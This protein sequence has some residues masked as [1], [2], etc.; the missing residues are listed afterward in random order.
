MTIKES[1]TIQIGDLVRVIDDIDIF[2]TPSFKLGQIL[3]VEGLSEAK[4][5]LTFSPPYDAG[6]WSPWRFKLYKPILCPEYL[7]QSNNNK[8][9]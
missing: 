9:K 4:H 7:K 1:Q 3:R 6:Q 8:G 5:Y 2:M